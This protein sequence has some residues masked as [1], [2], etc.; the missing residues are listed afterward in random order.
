MR[1]N[2]G[3]RF[4]IIAY[5]FLLLV[6]LI[7]TLRLSGVNELLEANPIVYKLGFWFGIIVVIG[8]NI[9]FWGGLSL[10]MWRII[11]YGI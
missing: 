4:G 2:S 5:L 7:L 6:D 8:L 1:K 10:L 3:L 9:V 11:K